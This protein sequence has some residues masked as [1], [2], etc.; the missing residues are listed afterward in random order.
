MSAAVEM[1]AVDDPAVEVAYH[2]I[3]EAISAA[4]GMKG[5]G[6]LKNYCKKSVSLHGFGSNI[7]SSENSRI[8]V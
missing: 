6:A 1:S 7:A 3:Q 4:Y 2:N 5:A 8:A